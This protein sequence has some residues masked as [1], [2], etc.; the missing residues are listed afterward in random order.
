[1]NPA[2]RG[3]QASAPRWLPALLLLVSAAA[4]SFGGPTTATPP[5]AFGPAGPAEAASALEALDQFRNPGQSS[6]YYL[7]FELLEM[8]RRGAGQT[9]QGRL[10]GSRTGEGAVLRIE[11]RDGCGGVRRFLLQNGPHAE[12]WSFRGGALSRLGPGDLGRPLVEGVEVTPFD[13]QMPYLYWPDV[14]VVA[15]TRVLGRPA[16]EFLFRG[17]GG[18]EVRAY[19]DT[20]FRALVK[21]ELVD[22]SGAVLKTL[23]LVDLKKVGKQWIPRQVDVRTES[24]RSKTR[25]DFTA[26]ALG[27]DLSPALF[28]PGALGE[29]VAGPTEGR[30]ERFPR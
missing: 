26:A 25:I 18:A 13:L 12:A 9:F 20:Q 5:P 6:P 30:M 24:T 14:S 23:S 4:P 10:W 27:L 8:P 1:M 7:E 11:V 19:L 28:L 15:V 2:G 22:S 21:T 16:D 17:A 29:E 3:R